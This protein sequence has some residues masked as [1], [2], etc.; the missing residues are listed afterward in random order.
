MIEQTS[1]GIGVQRSVVA[2]VGDI[3]V[4]MGMVSKL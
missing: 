4:A 3:W 2:V 1:I